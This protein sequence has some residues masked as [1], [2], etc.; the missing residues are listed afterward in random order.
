MGSSE[1]FM[2]YIKDQL[3]RVDGLIIKKMFGECGLFLNGK[4]F[5]LICDDQLFIKPT[6]EGLEYLKDPT[7]LPPYQRA[8]PYFIIENTDNQHFLKELILITE[9]ALPLPKPKKRK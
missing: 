6:I 8:K 3:A 5:G 1:S 4:M 7:F 9:K 2:M